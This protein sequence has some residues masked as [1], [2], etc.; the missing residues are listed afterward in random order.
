MPARSR[1]AGKPYV[2]VPRVLA[3]RC[4]RLGE[5]EEKICVVGGKS[6]R[7]EVA[8]S[9]SKNGT[10]AIM[11]A[12]LLGK[13][14]TILR[15]VPHIEDVRTMLKML[16]CL[17][18]RAAF[19]EPNCVEIDATEITTNE[20]P[21]ELVKKMR[22]SFCVTG[23]LLAR[24]GAARVPKPGGCD[25]GARP[26][27][28]HENG[29]RSLGAEVTTKHGYIE[30]RASRLE[31]TSIYLDFPSAGATQHLMTTACLAHGK[32]CI[33]NA[34]L[35][36]EVVELARFLNAMGARV[37]GAGTP[38]IEIEGVQKLHGTEFTILPDRME[39]GTF[40][41]AAAIT[42]GNITI[43]DV[44]PEH[45]TAVFQ[46]L[47][48]A[49]VTVEIENDFVRVSCS[50]RPLATDIKTMPHP[51]FPTDLQ[52]PFTAM[53]TIAE[54][55][56]VVSE[57]VHERRFKYIA[58]L[59]RM[60]ADI[61]Q[62]GNTAIVKG[63]ES[64]TGAEVTATDL[65]AGAALVIAGLAARGRTEISG[66]EHIDRGYEDI[67]GKLASLDASISRV[68]ETCKPVFQIA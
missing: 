62:E 59:Q 52:Q 41:I 61:T 54:G 17:G 37:S 38:D 22:A 30:A 49:R 56:S 48:E 42:R 29:L 19:V 9:G 53:L 28:F 32:T 27:D 12:A 6:L 25:L 20:A 55:T 43:L 18:V 1:R 31:G 26:I 66:V 65:R 35:E 58:E 34:A 68:G 45:C 36:P 8:V 2:L 63:V 10:L 57:N 64:L 3:T 44:I 46:K 16:Q 51:G 24:F 40:A 39:A 13:G 21:Y 67:V 50:Q 5:L 60:G 15:N 4:W 14:P 11:A 47:R 7:G 23:P 33:R